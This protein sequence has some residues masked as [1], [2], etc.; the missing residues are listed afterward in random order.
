M[1]EDDNLSFEE[2]WACLDD[3]ERRDFLTTLR[4]TPDILFEPAVSSTLAQE[5][6]WRRPTEHELITDMNKPTSSVDDD[7]NSNSYHEVP[8]VMEDIPE[9]TRLRRP[10]LLVLKGLAHG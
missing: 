7:T 9:W 5:P 6:W 8:L 10:G 2:L 1:I 3:R 4:S